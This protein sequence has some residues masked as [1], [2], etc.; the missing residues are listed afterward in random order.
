MNIARGVL[1]ELRGMFIGDAR[2]TIGISVLI[3]VVAALV[4]IFRV[5]PLVAGGVLLVG[6]LAIL[7]ETAIHKAR[8]ETAR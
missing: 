6:S 7:I 3:S 1:N 2:L 8:R 5:E 4:A